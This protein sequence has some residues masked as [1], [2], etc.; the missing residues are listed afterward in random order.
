VIGFCYGGPYAILGP[1]R[2]GYDAG[3]SCHG[4]QMLDYIGELDRLDRPVCI[5]WGDEDHQ[6]PA[7]VLDAYR[8]AAARMRNLELHV[9][10]GVLHGYMMPEN[11]KAFDRKTR[12]FSM[13]RALAILEGLRGAAAG[14]VRRK[15]G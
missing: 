12:D 13:A 15:A 9:F 6:A 11:V 5:I 4:S 3:I 2:L 7:D 8:G 1:K 10:P 14:Q